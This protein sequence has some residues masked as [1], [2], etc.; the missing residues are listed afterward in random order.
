MEQ[1]NDPYEGVFARN[2]LGHYLLPEIE[3][4]DAFSEYRT[5]LKLF[6]TAYWSESPFA[7]SY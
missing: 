3:D 7:V 2:E 5:K 4:D 1:C 6:L